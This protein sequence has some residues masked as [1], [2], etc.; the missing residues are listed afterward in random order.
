MGRGS[1]NDGSSLQ[2]Q[3]KLIISVKSEQKL[4]GTVHDAI[5]AARMSTCAYSGEPLREPIVCDEYGTLYNKESILTLIL[6]NKLM[7]TPSTDGTT[8]TTTTNYSHIKSL[9]KD[10]INVHPTLIKE[11]KKLTINSTH[12]IPK[13]NPALFLCPL[14]Q[15]EANGKQPYV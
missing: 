6:Q 14:T 3:R 12:G 2:N 13:S 1:G 4:D 7:N 10:I 11:N 8:P 15:L 9:K 5:I